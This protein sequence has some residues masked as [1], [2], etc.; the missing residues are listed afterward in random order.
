MGKSKLRTVSDGYAVP[1]REL[2][3]VPMPHAVDEAI[4][5]TAPPVPFPLSLQNEL[6]VLEN[7]KINLIRGALLMAGV[8]TERNDVSVGP[9]AQGQWCYAVTAKA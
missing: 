9:D 7:Q 6:R 8:D 2:V 4:A 5:A 1:V 3:P